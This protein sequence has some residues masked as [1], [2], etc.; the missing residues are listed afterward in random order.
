MPDPFG[1]P[2]HSC[3]LT[4]AQQGQQITQSW[5]ISQS[6]QEPRELGVKAS[7]IWVLPKVDEWKQSVHGSSLLPSICSV[8]L[9]AQAYTTQDF[10]QGLLR[11]SISELNMQPEDPIA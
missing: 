10:P 7:T 4:E 11:A 1:N 6:G 9:W 2:E 8:E 5:P 3:E